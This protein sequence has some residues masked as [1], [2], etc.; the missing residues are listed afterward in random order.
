MDNS[1]SPQVTLTLSGTSEPL[2][3]EQVSYSGGLWIGEREID[4]EIPGGTI[5]VNV[6]AARDLKNNEMLPHQELKRAQVSPGNGGIVQS[7]DGVLQLVI[8]PNILPDLA[9]PPEIDITPQTDPGSATQIGKIYSITTTPTFSLKKAATL[10]WSVAGLSGNSDR[11]SVY[12]LSNTTWTRVGGTYE[13]DTQTVNAPISEFGTYGLFEDATPGGGT[14]GVS[15]LAFSNRAF[16]PGGARR[17]PQAGG[18]PGDGSRIGGSL[19]SSTD[20]SFDLGAQATVRIEIY[21][22]NGRLERILEPGR[23]LTPGSHVV[24]W[25]GRNHNNRIVTSGLY[26]VVINADG[27]KAHQ[28]VAVVNN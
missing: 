28:T 24:T 16:T 8:S 6:Q 5:I 1:I 19:I 23:V 27:K 25:D 12:Q 4:E 9:D 2:T 13:S 21:S 7:L 14:A 11:L 20:I 3:I 10:I 17:L 22:R 18:P 15:N 26:I